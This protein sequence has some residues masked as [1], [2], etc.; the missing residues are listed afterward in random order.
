MRANEVVIILHDVIGVLLPV[1]LNTVA[2][3]LQYTYISLYIIITLKNIF[4][5][6][7]CFGRLAGDN[8][9]F[10]PLLR[11]HVIFQANATRFFSIPNT[12]IQ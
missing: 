8:D 11:R 6:K 2:Y 1:H 3:K 7:G 10:R 12:H 4:I 9:I 5:Q